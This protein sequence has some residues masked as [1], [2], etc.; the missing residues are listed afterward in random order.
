MIEGARP[1]AG[2]GVLV[3]AAAGGVGNLLVQ[4]ARAGG[5]RVIGAARGAG[6]L[7]VLRGLGADS[8]VDCTVPDWTARLIDVT[9]G[10]GADLVLDGVGGGTH[11]SRRRRSTSSYPAHPRGSLVVGTTVALRAAAARG[12][13]H[14]ARRTW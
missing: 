9:G 11:R 12:G 6:E 4:L 5:A 2:E 8:V 13:W 7:E 10:A 1:R 14:G 3:E